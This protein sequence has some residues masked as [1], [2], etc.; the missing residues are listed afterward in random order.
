[1]IDKKKLIEELEFQINNCENYG[2]SDIYL[3]IEMAKQIMK[4]LNQPTVNEWIPVEEK[5]PEDGDYLCSFDD[6]F[7]TRVSF[8]N[9]DWELWA[10]SGE[11]IAWKP[12]PNLYVKEQ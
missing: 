2:H 4:L 11:I 8:I 12:L 10:D 5:L 6:G 9:G 7:I 3:D 1:M